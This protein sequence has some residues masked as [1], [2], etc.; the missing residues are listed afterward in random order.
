M[1][2][3]PAEASGVDLTLAVN[4]LPGV[5]CIAK[6]LTLTTWLCVLDAH[7][8]YPA[9]FGT[10]LALLFD[11]MSS[12]PR[13]FDGNSVLLGI[14]ASHIGHKVQMHCHAWTMPPLL[15][16]GVYCEWIALSL[17][18][19]HCDL[20]RG[21]RPHRG[22]PHAPASLE[23]AGLH[24]TLFAFFRALSEPL[25]LRA[26]RYVSYTMLCV[27]WVY[28][29]A[30]GRGRLV[31]GGGDCGARFTVYFAPAL[32]APAPLCTLHAGV[33]LLLTLTALHQPPPQAAKDCEAPP[34]EPAPP[35]PAPGLDPS[36]SIEELERVFRAVQKDRGASKP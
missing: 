2:C 24:M 22:P 31:H 7:E 17:W 8:M 13:I 9:L 16:Y 3:A 15:S 6:T 12:P 26:G 27:G 14:F 30:L 11:R 35:P 32:Y 10:G 4:Y 25:L 28:A 33:V 5:V 29:V 18:A 21:Q 1:R 36:E 20:Q 34:G 23:I 19:L